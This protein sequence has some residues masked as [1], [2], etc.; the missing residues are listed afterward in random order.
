MPKG[1][2]SKQAYEFHLDE[3][4][5]LQAKFRGLTASGTILK[6]EEAVEAIREGPVRIAAQDAT[7]FR[8]RMGQQKPLP[9]DSAWTHRMTSRWAKTEGNWSAWIFEGPEFS[10]AVV[11]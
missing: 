8:R 10:I 3:N 11:E 5:T 6:P 7:E 1:A 2:A 9:A 4:G